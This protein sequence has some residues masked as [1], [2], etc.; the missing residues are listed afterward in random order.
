ME[1]N[2]E[3]LFHSLIE[4]HRD[5]EARELIEPLLKQSPISLAV[6]PSIL[7]LLVEKD[8]KS[9]Q[10]NIRKDF[11]QLATML[12]KYSTIKDGPYQLLFSLFSC[13]IY[14]RIVCLCLVK[15]DE[16]KFPLLFIYSG[17]LCF[18]RWESMVKRWNN[19]DI[20]DYRRIYN[21]Q[22][23]D[24]H[25]NA[26]ARKYDLIT[27]FFD[28]LS[29]DQDS[30]KEEK[31]VIFLP[32]LNQDDDDDDDDDDN[33]HLQDSSDDEELN[34]SKD[35]DKEEDDEIF[36]GE[37]EEDEEED[38][39]PHKSMK[40]TLVPFGTPLQ[41]SPTISS[42]LVVV[43]EGGAPIPLVTKTSPPATP[44]FR[45]MSTNSNYNYNAAAIPPIKTP[46]LSSPPTTPSLTGVNKNYGSSS[47]STVSA[48][49]TPTTTSPSV[50]STNK[51]YPSQK[52][53]GVSAAPKKP[54]PII[55]YVKPT[56]YSEMIKS[57]QPKENDKSTNIKVKLQDNEKDKKK[58][59]RDNNNNIKKSEKVKS[60]TPKQVKTH[61]PKVVYPTGQSPI[62][63]YSKAY[64]RLTKGLQNN[65]SMD[66]LVLPLVKLAMYRNRLT[67][68]DK[69]LR[70]F[71]KNN[72]TNANSYLLYGTFLREHFLKSRKTD[73]IECA[74]Q[75][76]KLD[77]LSNYGFS[78][79][80]EYFIKGPVGLN[81]FVESF[82]SRL[83]YVPYDPVLWR[84]IKN[85]LTKRYK[86]GTI[87]DVLT[88]ENKE[89]ILNIYDIVTDS[90][91][92]S[93]DLLV[94]KIITLT[95][96]LPNPGYLTE[97]L[98]LKTNH[99]RA[100]KSRLTMECTK[101]NINL[102]TI[103]KIEEN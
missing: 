8:S 26:N 62:E 70:F 58:R 83:C 38:Y 89:R 22:Q 74:I 73:L 39:Q 11:Y 54:A 49:A 30:V 42:A 82:S 53:T 65:P 51:N 78:L 17:L 90:L 14:Y 92:S 97:I 20:Y 64:L 69:I 99:Q 31:G 100:F 6:I 55:P 68:V 46:P 43:P 102:F 27:G 61:H 71:L 47:S 33:D 85:S 76:M 77:P 86:K 37:E 48:A 87:K 98:K 18:M 66:F 96:I 80:C 40:L 25:K 67:T 29:F 81:L 88:L 13:D 93:E 2:I 36:D 44:P 16:E 23:R 50:T 79:I 101:Y 57:K 56:C 84:T 9:Y 41:V 60:T 28:H 75:L 32:T 95:K 12:Q 91:I 59:K 52:A 10:D 21:S 35:D 72:P 94:D 5:D 63:Y 15:L 3:T 19:G 103:L 45:P 4:Q 34:I 1:W 24:I 7:R